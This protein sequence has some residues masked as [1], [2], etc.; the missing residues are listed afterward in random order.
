MRETVL[1][2]APHPDDETL[3]CGGTLLKHKN[4]GDKIYWMIVTNIQT[5]SGW[6]DAIVRKRQQEIDD[7]SNMYGFEHKF[8]L[9]FPT[10]E[11]DAIPYKDL[12]NRIMPVIQEVRPTIVYVPN[13]SDIHTD[14]QITFKA[15]TSCCKNFR[16]PFMN[17]I[18]MYECLSETE[19]AP[20]LREDVFVPNVFVDISPFFCRKIEIFKVYESEIMD[21]TLPR[22][23]ESISSLACYRGSHIGRQYAEAFCLLFEKIP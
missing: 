2:V 6:S 1:V 7:V 9:D 19:F 10:T 16:T 12:I 4:N 14:H 13:R 5:G 20:P 22:S 8:K 21:S 15:V 17:K 11:L 3:G 23:I 18:L